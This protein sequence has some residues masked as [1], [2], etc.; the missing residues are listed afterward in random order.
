MQHWLAGH[1]SIRASTLRSYESHL[2]LYILPSLARIPLD[3]LS[4]VD[5]QGMFD[6]VI[7]THA[8]SGRPIAVSTLVRIRA[9]LLSGLKA[10][11]RRD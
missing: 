1:R 8:R 6:T 4:V 2:R 7:E 5:V 10:A 11:M 3:K 9:T